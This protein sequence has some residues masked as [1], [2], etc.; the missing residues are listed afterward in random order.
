MV[1]Q[2]KRRWKGR[3]QRWPYRRRSDVRIRGR[4]GLIRG[5][6]HVRDATE[7]LHATPGRTHL[8]HRAEWRTYPLHGC[9]HELHPVQVRS[10]ASTRRLFRPIFEGSR[11]AP[12]AC[13]LLDT[14]LQAGSW[15]ASEGADTKRFLTASP[16]YVADHVPNARG[17]EIPGAG[18]PAALTRP[19]ALAEALTE[20]FASSRQLQPYPSPAGDHRRDSLALTESGATHRPLR[21]RL[22]RRLLDVE[23]IAVTRHRPGHARNAAARECP[24]TTGRSRPSVSGTAGSIA[25]R[26]RPPRTPLASERPGPSSPQPCGRSALDT[27]DHCPARKRPPW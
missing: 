17:R 19:E 27:A 4:L 1:N 26:P 7:T 18:H 13:R 24:R 11:A 25:L 8:A 5:L 9:P 10:H 22:V 6:A 21:A 15:E 23:S 16:R 2:V 3:R 12:T 14:A 20:F